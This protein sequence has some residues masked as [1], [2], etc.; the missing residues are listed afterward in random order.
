[1]NGEPEWPVIDTNYLPV[2]A[3]SV[4]VLVDDNGVQYD[5]QMVAGQVCY[6][7]EGDTVRPRN[8]WCIAYE[9][10]PRAEPRYY[11]QGEV[12]PSE[13]PSRAE[14]EELDL[15]GAPASSGGGFFGAPATGGGLFGAPASS[16]AG[17]FGAAPASS[18]GFFRAAP[19]SSGGGLFGAAATSG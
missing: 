15:F 8:D 19:A 16:G 4:P 7:A 2:G 1:M 12:R 17:L 9:G 11:K 3:V 14:R 6:G 13:G 18:G 10:A 5:T